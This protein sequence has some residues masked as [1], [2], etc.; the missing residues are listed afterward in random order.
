MSDVVEITR[1]EFDALPEYSCSLPTG[2]TIGK[3]WKRNETA[4]CA[5]P[6]ALHPFDG[7]VVRE[8]PRWILGEYVAHPNPALVGIRWLRIAIKSNN[9]RTLAGRGTGG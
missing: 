3:R 9:A 6:V 2:T 8:P 5:E 4:Y 1:A 7:T